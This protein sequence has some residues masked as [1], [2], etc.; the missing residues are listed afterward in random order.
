M[1]AAGQLLNPIQWPTPVLRLDV[2]KIIFLLMEIGCDVM[3]HKCEEAHGSVGGVA[4]A[5]K[6]AV[7]STAVENVG[8]E[9]GP[10]IDRD[11]NEDAY[12]VFL[13]V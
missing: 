1:L 9:R 11:D 6:L 12:D 10:S 13:F 8:E 5:D 4:F 2:S 7:N 3:T